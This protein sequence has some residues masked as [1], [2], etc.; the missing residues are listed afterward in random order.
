VAGRERDDRV[1]LRLHGVFG[2]LQRLEY[3]A[4]FGIEQACRLGRSQA[5][6]AALKEL[7][8]EAALE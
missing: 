7:R 3:L 4:C 5:E 6:A 2:R 1:A 8:V